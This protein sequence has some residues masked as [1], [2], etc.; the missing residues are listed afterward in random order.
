M[1]KHFILSE[2]GSETFWQIELSGYSLI[3][4]FG[5]TGSSGNVKF[6]ILKI[7]NNVLRNFKN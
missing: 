3:I 7:E 2:N 5:K 4:S 1:K 6:S